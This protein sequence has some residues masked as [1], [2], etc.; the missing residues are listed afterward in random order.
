[1]LSEILF[2]FLDSFVLLLFTVF[3]LKFFEGVV[4]FYC[5]LKLKDVIRWIIEKRLSKKR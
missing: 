2:M 4:N 1:M 5:V 3:I